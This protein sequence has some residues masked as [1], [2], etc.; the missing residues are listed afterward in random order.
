MSDALGWAWS[1][2]VRLASVWQAREVWVSFVLMVA[3]VAVTPRLTRVGGRAYWNRGL[4]TDLLYTL[5]YVGGVYSILLSTAANRGLNHAVT[6]FAP[7]LRQDLLGPLPV[8]AAFLVLMV[9]MDFVGYWA[10]R[11]SH[12]ASL[13]WL[14]HGIHHS[15]TDLNAFTAFRFHAGD[16][17]FRTLLQFVPFTLLGEPD[18][19]GVPLLWITVPLSVLL[20]SIAHVDLPWT[21]GRLGRVVI[22]P[23][24]HRIHHST[25]SRHHGSNFGLVFS[26]W[27]DLFG[28]ATRSAERPAAYGAPALD[29]P[30]SFLRQAAF[31]FLAAFRRRRADA[32]APPAVRETRS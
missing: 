6:R 5:F 18:V 10:H 8:V 16:V 11:L 14:F 4:L 1:V 30:E 2:L 3:L 17:F 9:A 13:L 32:T 22:S 29:V 21:F 31:P 24:F 23:A 15:Q 27:D 28:T 26:F 12:R 20:E 25:E 19:A 7:F